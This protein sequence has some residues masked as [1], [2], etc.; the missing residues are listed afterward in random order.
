MA[1]AAGDDEGTHIELV[2]A[3]IVLVMIGVFVLTTYR[4]R[5]S[6]V[7]G[8][9]RRRNGRRRSSLA[10]SITSAVSFLS[11]RR[12][13]PSN[14]RAQLKAFYREHR[15]EAAAT[16]DY[17]AILDKYRGREPEMLA[18][19]ERMVKMGRFPTFVPVKRPSGGKGGK[20]GTGGGGGAHKR[21][22]LTRRGSLRGKN[23]PGWI[24]HN[25]AHNAAA[26]TR[27]LGNSRNSGLAHA[28]VVR[29]MRP[30]QM[31]GLIDEDTQLI[32]KELI[33]EKA[34]EFLPFYREYTLSQQH[35]EW[36]RERRATLAALP[37][38]GGG[39]DRAEVQAAAGG[40]RAPASARRG[41][42]ASASAAGPPLAH[43]ELVGKRVRVVGIKSRPELNGKCGLADGYNA[44]KGRIR[45]LLDVNPGEPMMLKP[46]N[47]E[48]EA[49]LDGMRVVVVGLKARPD[50][51]GATGRA[52]GYNPLKGRY[53]VRLDDA[54]P[55]SAPLMLKPAN[56]VSAAASSAALLGATPA[57]ETAATTK[58]PGFHGWFFGGPGGAGG[59]AGV[60]AKGDAAPQQQRPALVR[61][62]S[63][64]LK[65]SELGAVHRAADQHAA[66]AAAATETPTRPALVRKRSGTLKPSDF[67]AVRAAASAAEDASAMPTATAP[68][69]SN[70]GGKTM[71]RRSTKRDVLASTRKTRGTKK[72][73][74][75]GWRERARARRRASVA[76]KN[77]M[78]MSEEELAGLAELE[79]EAQRAREEHSEARKKHKAKAKDK[80]KEA[81]KKA[82]MVAIAVK[83]QKQKRPRRGSV[84]QRAEEDREHTERLRELMETT[85]K[86]TNLARFEASVAANQPQAAVP[87]PDG[88]AKVRVR[89]RRSSFSGGSGLTKGPIQRAAGASFRRR[90]SLN[91]VDSSL[92][93]FQ[94][95]GGAGAAAKGPLADAMKKAQDQQRDRNKKTLARRGTKR[96]LLAPTRKKKKKR[97][98][99]GKGAGGGWRERAR[100]RRKA[101]VARK[102]SLN[103]S[104]EEL[105]GLAKL[106]AEAQR[107]REEHSEARK[108][109]KAKVKDKVKQAAK[110]AALVAI[111]LKKKAKEENMDE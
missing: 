4:T 55:T 82:A 87:E 35:K 31:A 57:T 99:K 73:K 75:G 52:D 6:K 10:D 88:Q 77:S 76:R 21:P 103:M 17:D 65:P 25:D 83:K 15:P 13:A 107:A 56:V 98:A 48:A 90:S 102:N 105:A 81:A 66:A 96:D 1:G 16:A 74:K 67:D 106:E 86:R 38:H 94:A 46:A 51:N 49:P 5:K 41:P 44:A 68:G 3:F 54:D 80:F 92:K 19:L 2:S 61:K 111:A 12:K 93:A 9:F 20:G 97:G 58:N 79:A 11:L 95:L 7:E 63:G 40:A 42:A 53:R 47:L 28:L 109:H 62:R 32:S 100:V 91:G 71:K 85:K 39:A 22:T 89:R 26:L 84:R 8:S 69:D 18:K 104:E 78:N 34:P 50:L 33:A 43:R 36:K 37:S 23:T 29:G 27:A 14:Y 72:K 64:T 24:A 59:G 110:K 108:K 60:G 101:S 45:V 30:D 70:R